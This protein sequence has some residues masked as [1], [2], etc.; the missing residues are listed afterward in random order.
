[1]ALIEL[2]K[3]YKAIIDDEDYPFISQY[4][5]YA[6]SSG[7]HVYA[8]RTERFGLRKDNK[9]RHI[10][11]HRVLLSAKEEFVD[12]VNG[13][14][15]D[16]RKNNLRLCSNSENSRNQINRKNKINSKFKGVK[17]NANCSTWSAR[18]TFN[19]KEIYI[20]SFK[21]EEDAAKAYNKAALEYFGQFAKVNVIQ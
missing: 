17:K 2:S 19:R 11:L 13:D 10:Y 20:G 7:K 16:N 8:C 18:I 1:M 3:G 21:N 5:W 14:T 6:H 4:R 15:L 9:K 12:H